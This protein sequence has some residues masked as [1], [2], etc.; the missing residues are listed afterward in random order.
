MLHAPELSMKTVLDNVPNPVILINPDSSIEY[1]NEA[2]EKLTGFP[3][4]EVAGNTPPFPW[5]PEE[6]RNEIHASFQE[7]MAMGGRKR[8]RTFQK[9]NGERF[10]VELKV[11]PVT[12][13]GDTRYFLVDWTDITERKEVEKALRDSEEKFRNLFENGQDAVM[14]ADAETGILIDVNPAGCKLLGLPKEKIVGM[15]QSQIHPP[16]LAEKYKEIF[17]MHV[18]KRLT[19][20]EDTVIQRADGSRVQCEITASVA[21]YGDKHII[22]GVFRDIT[23]WKQAEE[24]LRESQGFNTILLEKAPNQVV[25]INP[26][27]SI[28]YVNSSW[29]KLNGW[30]KDEVIGLKIP[31]PWWPEDMVEEFMK[32]FPLAMNGEDGKGEVIT[33]KK[34]GELYWLAMN[35]TPVKRD[36]ELLYLLINSV[37]ITEQ[38][39]AREALKE[40]EEKL[41]KAFR[42]SPNSV[43]ISRIKDGRF[44]EVNDTFAKYIGYTRE[45]LIGHSTLELRI[46]KNPKDRHAMLRE[47][48]ERGRVNDREVNFRLKS[49]EIRTSLFSAEPINIGGEACL[50]SGS[51]DITERKKSEMLLKTIADSSPIGVYIEQDGGFK[52]VNHNLENALGYSVEELLGTKGQ[53]YIFPHDRSVVRQKAIAML[54]GKLH[55]PYEYRTV[56]KDGS[57]RYVIETVDSITYDGK[58]AVLGNLIDITE[59]KQME[60]E[61]REHRD[62]LEKLVLKRTNELSDTN[63]RLKHEL[64]VRGKIEKQLLKAKNEAETANR[65]KS[66]FLT[67]TSHEI[68]TPIHG[69]MG[70]I[71]LV[72][73]SQLEPDQRQYLKM[74]MASAESLM[75]IINDI[76]DLSKI[77]ARQAEPEKVD[78]DLRA[79]IEDTTD[80]MAVAAFKKGLEFTSRI[81]GDLPTALVGDEGRL[82]QVLVNLIGNANKFTENGEIALSVEPVVV[83]DKE[84]ELHFSVRDTGIGIPAD[85]QGIIFEPFQQADG[86]INRKYGGTGLGLTISQRLIAGMGGRIW[87]ASAPGKGSTFHFTGKFARQAAVKRDNKHFEIPVVLRGMPVLVVD[88]NE[89]SRQVIME[90]MDGWGIEVTETASG[91]AALR[92]LEKAKMDSGA[93]RLTLIDKKMPEMSGFELAQ[94]ILDDPAVPT[95][96]VMM[97]PPDSVSNDF[98]RCQELGI[99]NYT[100]KPIRESRLYEAVLM[101]LGMAPRSGGES[102]GAI[103]AAGVFHLRI[104]VAED[105]VTSQLIARKTLEKMGHTVAIA[106]NGLE[107]TRLLE[108]DSYDLVLMDE[109]MPVMNGLE[110]TRHIRRQ[111]KGSGRHVPIVAMTAYAMKEDRGKCLQAGM[112]GYLPK[113]AKPD[114]INNVLNELFGSRAK[115]AAPSV[116]MTAAMKVFGGD[117]E[118]MKEAAGIFLEEDCPEQLA[119]IKNGI[120]RK[121]APAVKAAAHSVKGAARSLGA[122]VLGDLALRLEE[123]GNKGDLTNAGALLDEIEIEVKRFSDFFEEKKDTLH[124]V[125]HEKKASPYYR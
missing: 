48:K 75:N 8:E 15:H 29:E 50:I 107:A 102:G 6:N 98:H 14:L 110:A 1:V 43:V 52:Y 55:G 112:D 26:D 114:D 27:T 125:G 16:E 69:V 88:D 85:K 78:F 20:A 100:V 5:W 71:N 38:K 68:R 35:W 93:F 21:K 84:V 109:E 70:M 119:I 28:K 59:R 53:K 113:P 121:D 62:N 24:A 81:P 58:R 122:L 60:D 44:V 87:V 64:E 11:V 34:N 22:Q 108:Q 45:E 19:V 3:P 18:E 99:A 73:D 95:V 101:A 111:E 72:L 90:L 116:D 23:E 63:L 118:L 12:L 82:R 97:L 106:A 7:T 25:V 124:G 65:A 120:S 54:K 39:K 86:S 49:G 92:E 103:P 9:R 105:N 41:S 42:S 36:G 17:R 91:P 46:W 4:A 61:L 117:S 74:A 115:A 123:A 31:H 51:I 2:F 40:S 13:S 76:L 37:D 30:T 10:C 96:I 80:T 47:L 77:E 104:L 83:T 66:E 79:V 57:I 89:S 32:T 67:R 56:S 33:R 94:K